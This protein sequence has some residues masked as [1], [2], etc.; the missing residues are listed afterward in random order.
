MAAAMA[1][2]MALVIAP[3]TPAQA[4][5][6]S[7]GDWGDINQ[8]GTL[9]G[10]DAL[11]VLHIILD[12]G[13]PPTVDTLDTVTTLPTCGEGE[14]LNTATNV[15]VTPEAAC[16][17]G[18]YRATDDGE[19][20]AVPDAP[21]YNCFVGGFCA[22]AAIDFPPATYDYTNVYEGH[23]QGSEPALGA[24]CNET[25]GSVSWGT[26]LGLVCPIGCPL[27]YVEGKFDACANN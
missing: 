2:S 22:R 13:N 16:P 27:G 8:D 5:I 19:C 14:L 23:H 25:P 12:I 15:C 10:A 18:Q 3:V 6:R 1:M 11:G 26:G 21:S 24:G 9:N 4:D 20:E 7:Q 17:V